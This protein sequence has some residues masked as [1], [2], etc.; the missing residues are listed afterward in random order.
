MSNY[1]IIDLKDQIKKLKA[2][3]AQLE[4]EKALL[5]EE[6]PKR[7]QLLTQLRHEYN[8][9]APADEI[10][11]T[12]EENDS[13]SGGLVDNKRFKL[14][15]N[16]I[17]MMIMCTEI[18]NALPGLEAEVARYEGRVRD[19]VKTAKK[20]E[21][22]VAEFPPTLL[23]STA[24]LE[25][26]VGQQFNTRFKLKAQITTE[27]EAL[28]AQKHSISNDISKFRQYLT[29]LYD[30]KEGLIA[31]NNTIDN[32]LYQEQV[33]L[34]ILRKQHLELRDAFKKYHD[35]KGWEAE[36]FLSVAGEN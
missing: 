28:K 23:K 14:W 10:R 17:D 36:A 32:A 29:Q 25:E 33:Q 22:K 7:E 12:F 15:N 13:N 9:V 18:R 30:E 21:K 31:S 35:G 11:F 5:E 27:V 1:D 16:K 24:E 3:K 20:S 34:E 6:T 8:I 4:A 19:S 26:L 2:S